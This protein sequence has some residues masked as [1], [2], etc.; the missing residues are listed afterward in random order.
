MDLNEEQLLIALG[1]A[2]TQ[3]FSLREMFGTMTKPFHPG[4]AAEN[5]LQPALLSP[6]RLYKL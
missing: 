6:K 5:G 2:G 3:V 1:L 4:K